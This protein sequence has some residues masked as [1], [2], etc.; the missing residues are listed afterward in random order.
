M[1]SGL[2]QRPTVEGIVEYIAYG[3]ETIKYPDRLAKFMRNHP[4]VTQLD[5][6]GMLEMQEQRENVWKEQS[7]EQRV[8]ELSKDKKSAP[9][10]RSKR[11]AAVDVKIIG[12]QEFDDMFTRASKTIDARAEAISKKGDPSQKYNKNPTIQFELEEM[13]NQGDVGHAMGTNR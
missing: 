8:K 12:N 1:K 9:E 6:E 7:K 5:G 10:V 4:Y 3:Q 11:D 13:E 2:R